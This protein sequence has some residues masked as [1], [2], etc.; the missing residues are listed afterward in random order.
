MAF[1][2]PVQVS[3]QS[4]MRQDEPRTQMLSGA[5]W[6]MVDVIPN[7]DDA[8]LARRGGWVYASND[9]SATT[10]GIDAV[11]GLAY[12]TFT[13]GAKL[14]AIATDYGTQVRLFTISANGTV[15]DIGVVSSSGVAQNPVL[16]ANKLVIPFF[17][18]TAAVQY[19]DGTTLGNLA[20]SPPTAAFA[21]VYKDMTVL[22]YTS[23]NPTYV[24]FSDFGD[25]TVWD[26][27]NVLQSFSAPV[28]GLAALPNVLMVFMGNRTARMTGT[29]P[30]GRGS[31]ME[32]QDPLFNVGCTD[33]RSIAVNG[34]YCVFANSQGVYLTN[35][36]ANV[37]DVTE[38]AGLKRYWSSLLATYDASSWTL[39]GGFF[40]NRYVISIMNGSTFVDCLVFDIERGRIGYRFAN[41]KATSFANAVT[42]SEELYY[43]ARNLPRV[44][45]MSSCWNK[46]TTKNDADG[47]AVAGYWETPFYRS[48]RR[49]RRRWIPD[50]A[51]ARWKNVYLSYDMRDAA[52]DN[53]ILTVSYIQNPEDSYTALSTTLAESTDMNRARLPLDFRSFGVAFKVAQT[54]ASSTSRFYAV[55]LDSH[56]TESSKVV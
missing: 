14:C 20:G 34:T 35:G 41:V 53:P 13:G 4:G 49:L 5:L 3:F 40:Q 12:A 52:S 45:Y 19:Y 31:D 42:T 43:G 48:F 9:I 16:H 37:E 39:A 10:A 25:P 28:T 54:N 1:P 32:V 24:Y 36:T 46:P 51:R 18:G 8:P 50:N 56:T 44:N 6:N 26:T 38:A 7:V 15:A 29:Q 21:T 17:G 2:L 23:A 30:P 22:G 47:A 33:A 27:T 55:E 11:N